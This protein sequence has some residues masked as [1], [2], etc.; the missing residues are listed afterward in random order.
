MKQCFL[1]L[2]FTLLSLKMTAQYSTSKHHYFNKTH[3]S[4]VSVQ[5]KFNNIQDSAFVSFEFLVGNTNSWNGDV[6]NFYPA[7]QLLGTYDNNK[8]FEVGG[9]A[10]F[11]TSS[12]ENLDVNG[13]DIFASYRFNNKLSVTVDA[14]TFL[15]NKT[16]LADDLG[17]E[18]S[19]YQLYSGRL[20]YA[21]SDKK[22][23]ILGYSLLNDKD[24]LQQSVFAEYDYNANDYFTFI[25][26][27]A[28]E[29][30]IL[31]FN[32]ANINL[33]LGYRNT[34]FSKSKIPIKTNM[35]LFP[36]VVFQN[37]G[38]S[39]LTLLFSVDF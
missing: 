18:S 12:L 25:I 3:K 20:Q 11:T 15:G 19:L 5:K 30:D 28:S 34:F 4:R 8:N 39:P 36:I 33:G 24:S 7:L 22:S 31:Q 2:L 38:K 27:Y 32:S 21:I 6:Y 35:A 1:F 29:T 26:G 13:A 10:C 37:S 9:F 16:F 23:A 17:Y 14:Y